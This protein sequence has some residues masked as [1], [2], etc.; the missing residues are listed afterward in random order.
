MNYRLTRNHQSSIFMFLEVNAMMKEFFF[1]FFGGGGGG[2]GG[3]GWGWYPIYNLAFRVYNKRTE[4]VMEFV[5]FVVDDDD[6][7]EGHNKVEKN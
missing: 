3:G 7:I 2:G 5:N 6:T 1:F 4:I